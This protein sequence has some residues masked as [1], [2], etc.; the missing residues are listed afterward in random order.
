MHAVDFAWRE[1]EGGVF[2]E[3]T[4]ADGGEVGGLKFVELRVAVVVAF[5]DVEVVVEAGF[6]GRR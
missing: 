3:E 5:D 4:L 6:A 2:E 1:F